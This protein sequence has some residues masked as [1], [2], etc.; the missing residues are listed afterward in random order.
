MST[1]LIP[2]MHSSEVIE[3]LSEI[4]RRQTDYSDDLII[5]KLTEHNNNV[6]DIVREYMK[7]SNSID[8][9]IKKAPV[10]TNQKIFGEIRKLMDDA[11]E[12]YRKK[13]ELAGT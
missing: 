4:V 3:K 5:K 1:N 9:K 13:K 8:P 2:A 7:P 10:T 6:V 12:A 11:G